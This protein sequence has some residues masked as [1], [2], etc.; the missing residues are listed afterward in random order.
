MKEYYDV[1]P[2]G[3]VNHVGRGSWT[4]QYVSPVA[5]AQTI[6]DSEIHSD[7]RSA[8]NAG[9]VPYPNTYRSLYFVFLPPGVDSAECA[10]NHWGAYHSAFDDVVGYN[11]GL[12]VISHRTYAVV[13]WPGSYSPGWENAIQWQE[14]YSSHELAE[15]VTNPGNGV[16][17]FTFLGAAWY[18]NGNQFADGQGRELAD[19][20]ATP[21]LKFGK[22][23]GYWVQ[24]LWSNI[25]TDPSTPGDH[26]ILPP[27]TTN[28]YATGN[29]Q[30]IFGSGSAGVGFSEILDP[31]AGHLPTAP[32]HTYATPARY[33]TGDQSLSVPAST[34]LLS[35]AADPN[36]LPLAARLV[37]G[38]SSGTV[39]VNSDGSFSYAPSY[40]FVGTDSFTVEV[41]D[42]DFQSNPVTIDLNV[43]PLVAMAASGGLALTTTE[44]QQFT[45]ALAT[46]TDPNGTG[47]QQS[48]FASVQ[49]GDGG[50]PYTANCYR[51]R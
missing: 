16:G 41:A 35:G 39:D 4:G 17:G 19:L 3:A 42:G 49:W 47:G 1:L 43:R 15:A 51:P 28:V 33:F 5:P 2:F 11:Q 9:D 23:D 40:N 50:P 48:Y 45:G 32:A 37:N 34:G 21:N 44:G 22:Y 27:G 24:A 14:I 30:G 31:L 12:T 7:L 25:Y 36:G 13:P 20:A 18:A 38:P 26:R 29:G 8:I 10:A 6:T 46:F